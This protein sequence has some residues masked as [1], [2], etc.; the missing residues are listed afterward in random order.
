MQNRGENSAHSSETAAIF[1]RTLAG[2]K[3]RGSGLLLVGPQPTMGKACERF[4][5]ESKTEPRY[6]LFVKT[7][8][9]N[10][11]AHEACNRVSLGSNDGNVKIIER[12][13]HTRSATVANTNHDGAS[14]DIGHGSDDKSETTV[15]TSGSLARLGITISEA[16]D[17]F[18]RESGGL[19]SGELR[20]CFDSLVPLLEEY[21]HEAVFRFLH[22]LTARVRNVNGMAHF[23]LPT[24]MDSTTAIMLAP[25]FDA[26]VE[27]RTTGGE[28]VHRW[29][30]VRQDVTTDWLSL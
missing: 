10:S 27:V 21:N 22:I 14:H 26:V 28:P 16:I 1:T 13:T 2:L 6:R 11:H 7:D 19:Q 9:A 5:G 30:L 3:R 25:V 20:M 29:Q 18:E 24:E 23:H 15:L 8:G 4:L 12:A 17:E